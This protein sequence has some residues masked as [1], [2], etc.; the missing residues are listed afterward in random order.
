M[1][2]LPAPRQI[3]L[4]ARDPAGP[5]TLSTHEAGSGD[6]VVF[7]HGFPDIGFGWRHQLPAV[8]DAGFR[9][10]APDQRGCGFS[11][12]PLDPSAYGLSEL[13]GD[14]VALLDELEIDRAFSW[15]TTGAGSWRGP[16]Q[17]CIQIA[18]EA[19][20]A[21]ARPTW[22][23]RASRPTWPSWVALP[24]ASTSRGFRKPGSVF[25]PDDVSDALAAALAH[26]GPALVDIVTDV[27]LV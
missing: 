14:L 27:S 22:P 7:C 9:A 20:R 24:S 13:T 18:C 19:W 15:G 25:D 1:T 21:C 2:S 8:A 11:T 17:C 23:F 10:I 6:A 12:A 4:P 5:I 3:A 16:C 26:R